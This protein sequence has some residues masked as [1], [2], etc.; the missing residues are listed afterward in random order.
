MM[1]FEGCILCCKAILNKIM[2]T[3]NFFSFKY[4]NIVTHTEK[5]INPMKIY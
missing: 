4:I 2:V 3:D 5:N 1:H